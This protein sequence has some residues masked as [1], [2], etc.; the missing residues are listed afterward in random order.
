MSIANSELN[1]QLDNRFGSGTPTTWYVGVLE[2]QP[3]D[4]TGSGASEPGDAAY[5]RVALTNNSTNFPAA[6]SGVQSIDATVE[7]PEATEAW[8]GTGIGLFTASTGGTPL[9]WTTKT[10]T[11]PIGGT[12]RFSAG[13][14]TLTR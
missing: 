6:S 9:Y 12:V 2:N 11:V 13:D 4:N 1:T 10:I 5:A 7:F 14:I 3:S 8:A